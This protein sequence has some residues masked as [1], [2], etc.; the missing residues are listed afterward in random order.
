MGMFGMDDDFWEQ[1]HT[2]MH[3]SNIRKDNCGEDPGK[4]GGC[5][6]ELFP[7]YEAELTI[8]SLDNRKVPIDLGGG[9]IMP[10]KVCYASTTKNYY[11]LN[12]LIQGS[13]MGEYSIAEIEM[14]RNNRIYCYYSYGGSRKRFFDSEGSS[15]NDVESALLWYLEEWNIGAITL[16][17]LTMHLKKMIDSMLVDLIKEMEGN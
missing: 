17:K 6:Q 12:R 4:W 8:G 13:T 1:Y 9:V 5:P 15:L 11:C 14:H 7:G 3:H 10:W 16:K 2:K